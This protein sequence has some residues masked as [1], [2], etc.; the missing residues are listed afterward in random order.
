V[1]QKA[2]S[3]G[4]EWWRT[5]KNGTGPF[6][7]GKWT[8]SQSLS[9]ERNP[10]YYAE[11]TSLNSVQYAYYAGLSMDLYETGAID[12]TGVSADYID[13]VEDQN[14]P[15]YKNLHISTDLSVSYIGFNCSQPPFDDPLVRKA[16]SQAI[17]KDKI[18]RLIY[19]SMEKKSEGLLPPGMP[20]YNSSVK[21]PDFDPA[22]ARAAIQASRYGDVSKLPAITFT[23]NGYGGNVGLLVQSL[24]YQWQQNLG[25][26]VR[27][28]QLD[29][30]RYF[31]NTRSEIDQMYLMSW[32]ADY[33]HPQ[34]FLDV[35][36]SSNTDYNYGGY[37]NAAFDKLIK[38]ANLAKNDSDSLPLYQQAEK[39]LV[40]DTA[41]IPLTFGMN[42]YLVKDYVKNYTVSPLGFAQLQSVSI[43][44]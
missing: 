40:D 42:Y 23:V 36:F 2:V 16:F 26:N 30:D 13:A 25:V 44:R 20:G 17:D 37:S 5:P 9:L 32:I 27:I 3:Q 7:L 19:R 22:A 1:D 35:L 38:Q 33:P 15:F 28:R 18:I 12:V 29:S 39:I 31:Y 41:C 11:K 43:S 4:G 6:Q 10:L 8:A 14:G 21:G 34:D 24:V